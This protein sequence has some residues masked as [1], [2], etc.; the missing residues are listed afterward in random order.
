[1]RP[2]ALLLL[3]PLCSCTQSDSV[4]ISTARMRLQEAMYRA[5]WPD[6]REP[7]PFEIHG[8]WC[9]CTWCEDERKIDR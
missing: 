2:L 5:G 4:R 8:A 6:E 1:M 7:L 3:L 9:R